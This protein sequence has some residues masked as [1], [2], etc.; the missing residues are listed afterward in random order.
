MDGL[1][2]RWKQ[3]R[4]L[5]RKER[6]E[7]EMEEEM[8]FHLRMETEKNVRAGM[9]PQEARRAARLAFGGVE[10]VKEEVR[11]ARWVRPL[12]VLA[13]DVRYALRMLRSRPGFAAA[14]IL[15]VALGV[16][17]TTAV[18]SVVRGVLLQPLPYDAPERL[19][20][21]YQVDVE[22]PE[23]DLYV[24]APHFLDYR[25]RASAFESLATIYT[26]RPTGADLML[27]GGPTRVRVLPV[28]ADYFRVLRREP[29][30]GRS[31]TRAEEAGEPVAVVSAGLWRRAGLDRPRL[32]TPGLPSIELDGEGHTVIGVMP[33]GFEDPLAGPVDAWVPQDLHGGGAQYPGNHFLSVIGRLAPGVT[34]EQARQEMAALDAALLAKYPEV[35]DDGGFRLVP[36]HEDLVARARP[37]L[38]LAMGAVVLVLLIACLNL[39]NLLLVRALG[40]LREVAVRS[41]LGA[42][43]RRIAAQLLI[44]SAVI[45]S[46]GGVAGVAV[47]VAGLEALLRVGRDAVPRAS[48]IGLDGAVLA[49]TAA[50]AVL[51]GCVAGVAPALRLSRASPLGALGASTRGATGARRYVRLRRVLV[52]G[53]VGLALTLLVGA[54]ALAASVHRLEQV[55]LGVRTEGVL[56]FELNL[57]AGRYDA[58]RR[59]G[60]HRRL[61]RHLESLPGVTAAG[62]ATSLP[63]T[64]IFYQWGTRPTTGPLAGEDGVLFDGEQR[65]VAGR[66]FEALEIPLLEGRLFDDR[67]GPDAPAVA[68]VSRRLADRLFPGQTALDQ[69]I[70]MGGVERTVIG[71]VGDVALDPE[72]TPA[73][74]VY[75]AHA[76]FAERH[77]TLH[78][79]LRTKGRGEEILPEVRARV[80]ELDPQLV[81]HQPAP[82][83]KVVDRGR[84]QR[85]FAFA[86]VGTFGFLALALAAVGLYGVLSYAVRQ[87][88][89]EIGVRVAMGAGPGRV[90]GMVL[91][92]GLAV[93]FAGLAVGTLGAV[94]LGRLLAAL[95]FRTEITEPVVLGSA[96]AVLAAAAAAASLLPAFRA[97]RVSPRIALSEP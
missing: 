28:S 32:G 72:G 73:F 77:W 17:G 11:E 79:L 83:P 65:I 91:R 5:F 43:Q 45:A 97:L 8:A 70:R 40:R 31:F 23:L 2:G 52:V 12:D 55:D 1:K 84:S 56:T 78:Y 74:H 18:F 7:R 93:T 60:L 57:P 94:A 62:A 90:L 47:A 26:Y 25:D 34:P 48:E 4:A 16:G 13:S 82:L 29:V 20:R 22:E 75:H 51:I 85:R 33:A 88:T 81:V 21:L 89:R 46:V 58:A 49:F 66:Y 95:V 64:G 69:G 27:E 41:A 92:D 3:L 68:V 44:E 67:D 53:Q 86:L 6:A 9:S 61:T 36:L 10:A 80:A 30:R 87:R 19:V 71:V 42:A 54:S 24:T 15:T 35:D 50:V 38:L 76:Q 14:A 96:A 39:A 59:T 63:A 37:A